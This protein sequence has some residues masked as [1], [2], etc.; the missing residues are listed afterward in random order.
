ME[1]LHHRLDGEVESTRVDE[2]DLF[3]TIIEHMMFS[4][5]AIF[6]TWL[7]ALVFVLC[8]ESI[9]ENLVAQIGELS[10]LLEVAEELQAD[11]SGVSTL[12]GRLG[13]E[14]NDLAVDLPQLLVRRFDWLFFKELMMA[15]LFFMNF[16]PRQLRLDLSSCGI[17]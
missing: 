9:S 5:S 11:R 8:G 6:T 3:L 13:L 7:H 15:A 1:G 17:C 4:V 2:G 10:Y 12:A 14:C 16:R